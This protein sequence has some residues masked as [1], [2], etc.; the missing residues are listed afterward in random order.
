MEIAV[1]SPIIK[2]LSDR[3]PKAFSM[4]Q[5]FRVERSICVD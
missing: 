4:H 5:S 2:R 3:L 1:A